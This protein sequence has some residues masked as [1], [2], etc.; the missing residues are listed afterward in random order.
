MHALWV[1]LGII[2]LGLGLLDLFLTALNYDEAGFLA[3]P[4]CSLLWRGVRLVTRR[5]SR[6]WRPIA[7]RQITGLQIVLSVTTWLGCV[8]VGF[9]LIYYG[10]MVGTNFQFDGR[11]LGPGI[12]AAMYLSAAQLSTVGT[13]QIT[14]ETDLLRAL[15]I[16]ETLSAALLV[17]LILTFLLGVY[18]VVRD[19]RSLCSNF[20]SSDADAGDPVLSLRSYFPAGQPTG[21][22]GLLQGI[23]GSFWSYADGLRLHHI[24]YYFQSGRDQF[25]LPYALHMLGGSLGALR[26]GLPSG[27][28]GSIDP[29][30]T[31]LSTQFN[32]FADY[33]HG[34]LGWKSAAVPELVSFEE[35][36]AACTDRGRA[37]IWV[38]RF[39]RLNRDAAQMASLETAADPHDAYSRYRQW[40]PFAY[41]AA[42][43]VTAVSRDLD[44]QP[45]F[46]AGERGNVDAGPV[47]VDSEAHSRFGGMLTAR[48]WRAFLKRWLAVP[49][50]GFT[51]L[52]GAAADTF[53]AVA[54]AATSVL[55]FGTMTAISPLA[56]AMFGG[57]VAMY[58]ASM[59]G[60]ATAAGRKLTTALIVLPA[61]AGAVLGAAVAHSFAL[62]TAVLV[63]VVL[64]GVW[65]GGFGPRLAA[66]G[67]MAFMAYYY[68]LLLHFPLAQTAA[69]VV[70]AVVGA[71]WAYL[72]RFVLIGEQPD[73]V[74]RDGVAAFR[75]RLVLAFDPLIDAVS[76]ARWDPD[77]SRR[78]RGDMRQL[79]RSAA[80]LQGQL[81]SSDPE[82][83]GPRTSPGELRLRL[84][85][86]ELAASNTA[87]AARRAACAGT[88]MSIPLRAQLAGV[89]ERAQARLRRD[90]Q[91]ANAQGDKPEKDAHDPPEGWPMQARQLHHAVRELLDAAGGMQ[92]IEAAD[93]ADPGA[94]ARET[95]DDTEPPAP[96]SGQGASMAPPDY[97]L[98]AP[99]SRRAVQAAV[100]TGLAVLLGATVTTSHQYWAALAAF[101][102]LGGTET[103]EETVLK[104]IA[105]IAGTIFGAV[106][107]FWVTSL[108]GA[109]PK[110]ILPLLAVSVFAAMYLRPIS[111]ALMVFW[112]TML[113]ALLYEFLGTL[114]TETLE[115]RIM[116]TVIGAAIALGAAAVL[117]PVRTR[118]KLNNDAIAFLQ[119]LDEITQA[120]L[121]RL[122]GGAAA[123]SLDDQALALDQRYRRLS[124]S[125]A[126]LRRLPGAV[127]LDGIERR[128]TAAAALTYYG[129][130]LIKAADAAA[131]GTSDLPE[132]KREHLAT[133]TRDNLSAL[134]NVLRGETPGP[135]HESDDFPLGR[136]TFGHRRVS[137]NAAGEAVYF[138]RRINETVLATIDDLS[139]RRGEAAA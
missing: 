128:L 122:G 31:Q 29:L 39:L 85:D 120:C 129:R 41:R 46:R 6:R 45:I 49:D 137:G 133:I 132:S 68:G 56:P 80:F 47:V 36:S 92:R 48:W 118:E 43:T 93:L 34:Q 21:L 63:A 58:A 126:P 112:I 105:R 11:N 16:A 66:M 127:R 77:V 38:A 69:F 125:A 13:S 102:V 139:A 115:V 19:L 79:H 96:A 27:H 52:F 107:G 32:Q 62:S 113:I 82:S 71:I 28:A 98:Q 37:D 78:V 50:P 17:S 123:G 2:I 10:L 3:T 75:A 57:M 67:Q 33:L 89:L 8:V 14:P 18:Q 4:L 94:A 116:E 54:A 101:L 110:V 99:T 108:T 88:T 64:V 106:I 136:D 87:T 90:S 70:A 97:G 20:V 53:A 74:L 138:L 109:D 23:A 73:R 65:I 72:F 24:A 35:F 131:P 91:D 15:T 60:D 61:V 134:M 84:F 59:P 111:Y 103:V 86:T 104:G 121:K 1:A 51:R 42:Q 25:A 119:M 30:L 81:Q 124:S 9:G 12:F 22:D 26:W 130:H 40:L 7:L 44:Y 95:A 100:A 114:T 76:G 55:L 117:L 5:L 83:L 135:T